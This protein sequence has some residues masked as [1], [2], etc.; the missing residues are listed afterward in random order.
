MFSNRNKI[1]IQG[2]TASHTKAMIKSQVIELVRNEKIKT[3]PAKSKALKSIFDRLVTKAK[4][5]TQHSRRQ[6]ESFFNN[7]D[8]AINRFF[9][10][11]ENKL[12]D[13]NSGYTRVI[14]TTNRA[15]D[16]A[17]QVYVMLVN[18]EAKAKK[19]KVSE[20]LEK[21]ET[22]ASKKKSSTKKLV[23]RKQLRNQQKQINKNYENK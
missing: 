14:R 15:G 12:G 1:K 3:T 5:G 17:E 19:S 6:V 21:Q 11:V 23:I 20:A 16:N 2:K 18:V 4:V 22:K 8:R 10:Q 13:R 9:Y 7:N